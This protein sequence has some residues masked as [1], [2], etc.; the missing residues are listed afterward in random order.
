MQYSCAQPDFRKFYLKT[1]SQLK[2]GFLFDTS[3][4]EMDLSSGSNMMRTARTFL[5]YNSDGITQVVSGVASDKYIYLNALPHRPV[6]SYPPVTL[7]AI[8]ITPNN[9]VSSYP[10]VQSDNPAMVDTLR[11]DYF[12]NGLHQVVVVPKKYDGRAFPL[13]MSP[14]Y[15]TGLKVAFNVQ[16][17]TYGLDSRTNTISLTFTGRMP[18]PVNNIAGTTSTSTKPADL[19]QFTNF[20]SVGFIADGSGAYS[21]PAYLT[22]QNIPLRDYSVKMQS[23]DTP[24]KVNIDRLV[25]VSNNN[26]MI[27]MDL[28]DFTPSVNNIEP[29]TN[30]R[31]TPKMWTYSAVL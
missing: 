2:W 6:K 7:D 9:T 5:G 23:S 1:D 3:K 24:E 12:N 22:Y 19:T 29:G 31:I 13:Y 17:S 4:N 28:N 25:Q 16:V 10:L 21:V 27:V 30:L 14:I 26:L 11:Y 20:Y 15:Q 18:L 8:F